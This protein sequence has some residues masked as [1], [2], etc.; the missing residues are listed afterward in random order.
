VA[1]VMVSPA[2]AHDPSAPKLGE[3]IVVEG[4]YQNRVGTSDAASAGSFTRQ[5]IEDRPILRPGEVL[6]LVRL[7]PDTSSPAMTIR[8]ALAPTL[9][10]SFTR[11]R[12]KRLPKLRSE[13]AVQFSFL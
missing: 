8:K 12:Q 1:I 6:E 2:A 9:F 5:L 7:C 13:T 11:S 10:T 3:E 4:H